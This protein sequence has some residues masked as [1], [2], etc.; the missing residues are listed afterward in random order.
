MRG[1]FPSNFFHN[2]QSY[3]KN[4]GVQYFLVNF[5]N[6]KL[7]GHIV[8]HLVERIENI[9][10]VKFSRDLDYFS[11][12]ISGNDSD[13]AAALK[14]EKFE[15]F[16]KIVNG[17]PTNVSD[18]IAY[19]DLCL[20]LT[21]QNNEVK[22]GIFGEVEGINGNKLRNESF[23][24]GKQE[25]CLFGIG[26]VKGENK[27]VY[28]QDVF[29]NGVMRVNLYF[30][31]S[32][33][34][35]SDFAE[36]ISAFNFLFHNGPQTRIPYSDEEFSFFVDQIKKGWNSNIFDLLNILRQYLHYDDVVGYNPTEN[37]IITDLQ[38]APKK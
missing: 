16:P 37:T 10:N 17:K 9:H 21:K 19:S 3:I 6:Q 1:Q 13:L 14:E 20:I 32:N 36:T 30:E 12:H 8:S 18:A 31:I 34:I 25:P 11:F 27:Q 29:A 7:G 38:S 15:I 24:G 2:I 23:W 4:W 33:P 28:F 26:A 35:V 5:F 22:V